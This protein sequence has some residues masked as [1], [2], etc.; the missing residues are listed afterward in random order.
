MAA[1]NTGMKFALKDPQGAI[2]HI[3]SAE[4]LVNEATELKRLQLAISANMVNAEVK[5]DGLGG[6]D[7]ARM[8]RAIGQV[9]QA[10]ELR[11]NA[12]GGPGVRYILPA[13]VAV[14]KLQ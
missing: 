14:R 7:P 10:F 3:K 13:P 2:A 5:R 4:P 1:V 9:V 8:Q 6:I 11:S 12:D